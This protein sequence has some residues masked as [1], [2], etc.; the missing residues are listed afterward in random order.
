MR[1]IYTIEYCCCSVTQLC[2]PLCDSMDCSKPV[3]PVPHHLPKFAQV[4]V[5]CICDAR[6][7]SHPLTPLLLHSIFPSIRDLSNESA[8]RSRWPK[9]WSFSFIINPSN[10]YS[11]L[12]SLKIDWFDL[13]AVQGTLK[14]LLQ[15]HSLKA[16]EYYSAIK[17][18]D[19]T[20]CSN[21]D[22]PK[23]Y[24]IKWSKTNIIIWYHLSVK[25]KN[26]T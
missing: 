24:L 25:S 12:I 22:E 21:M 1:Y 11:G 2:P 15:Y 19:H 3:L 17:K 16:I 9:Y 26:K 8:V 7:P 4:H 20:I 14:S 5:H 6:Q 13:L 23:D 10:E 18:W